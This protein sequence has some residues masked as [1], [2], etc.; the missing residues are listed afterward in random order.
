M[1]TILVELDS[2]SYR[3]VLQTHFLRWTT[4]KSKKAMAFKIQIFKN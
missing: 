4:V 3:N 1:R 2:S